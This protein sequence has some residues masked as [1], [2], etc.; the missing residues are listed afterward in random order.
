MNYLK[1]L[2]HNYEGTDAFRMSLYMQRNFQNQPQLPVESHSG[3]F[4]GIKNSILKLRT[5]CSWF[6]TYIKLCPVTIHRARAVCLPL[7]W[8]LCISTMFYTV[9]IAPT[10]K[11]N[12]GFLHDIVVG[13]YRNSKLVRSRVLL[14]RSSRYPK[15]I[16]DIS[17]RWKNVESIKYHRAYPFRSHEQSTTLIIK[18]W[19]V[20]RSH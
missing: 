6:L 1:T 17:I 15:Y 7:Y 14:P 19:V 18:Y 4:H 12:K 11:Y 8:I 16:V 5:K 13:Q 3:A 2:Y 20:W 10:V 9:F